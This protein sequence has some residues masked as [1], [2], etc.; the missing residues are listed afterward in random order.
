MAAFQSAT[1]GTSSTSCPGHSKASLRRATLGAAVLGVLAPCGFAAAQTTGTAVIT[2]GNGGVTGA[3][4]AQPDFSNTNLVNWEDYSNNSDTASSPLRGGPGELVE[5]TS[6]ITVNSITIKGGGDAGGT[7]AGNWTITI[8][9]VNANNPYWG[10]GVTIL[11]TETASGT[12]IANDV[13]AGAKTNYDMFTLQNPI[14]MAAGTDYFFAITS[15]NQTTNSGY[16]AFAKSADVSSNPNALPG[17][18]TGLQWSGTSPSLDDT[19]NSTGA[20]YQYTYFIN[21]SLVQVSNNTGIWAKNG[22][23]N[24]STNASDNV[25]WVNSAP[26]ATSASSATFGTDG[27]VITTTPTV[28]LTSAQQVATL[29]FSSPLGYVLSGSVVS[30]TSQVNS[31]SGTNTV[32]SLGIGSGTISVSTGSVLNVSSLS[33]T[34]YGPIFVGGGGVANVG[35]ISDPPLSLELSGGT[36][37]NFTGS[38]NANAYIYDIGVPTV[39]DTVNLGSNNTY[40]NNSLSGNGTVIIGPGSVLTTAEYGNSS[41]SGSLSGTG[42]LQLGNLA[43]SSSNVTN[44]ATLTGT[45]PSFSGPIIVQYLQNLGVGNGASIGNASATNILTLDSGSLEA[46]GAVTVTATTATPVP[47]V[48]NLPQN[49]VIE[50]TLTIANGVATINTESDV[51]VTLTGQSSPSSTMAIGNTL[52]LSGHISGGDTLTKTGLGT[53]IL[54]AANTYTGGTNVTEGTLVVGATGALPANSALTVSNGSLVQLATGT[55]AETLSSLS[56]DSNSAL[57][58][59]N[60]HLFIDYGSG[61]DP[62]A[63]IAALIKSG[64]NNGTWTGFGITSSAAAANSGS[65][66]IAYADSADPG[67]PAGLASGQIEIMYTLL[68]DANL[69]GKVN[70]ADFAILATNFNKA[71][72]GSS[73]WD[74]GDFNYDAKI[75]GADFAALASNFNKGASQAANTAALQAFAEANGLNASVP[76]PATAGLAVLGAFGVLSRRRRGRQM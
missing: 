31:T 30:V 4:I 59:T 56:I 62:I 45:S 41:F 18:A 23:G 61:A 20:T 44:T 53:L 50:D 73:G 5:P 25:N 27:G 64:Y 2:T 40:D 37:F 70:G 9:T 26:P 58:I 60:N 36:T 55:H 38:G 10:Q 65:Y 76:E 1:G 28:T 71:V 24:W 68:G 66:G 6:N 49:M 51:P 16:Y 72:T 57:D 11:D 67:N 47:A 21:G 32:S 19:Q 15:N 63:S 12:P 14:A 35:A 74:Q 42:T 29:T 13:A 7:L 46:V 33:H 34:Q 43:S 22:N 52:T 17:W 8:G 3:D 54:A 39:N 75:N 48:V 69:D